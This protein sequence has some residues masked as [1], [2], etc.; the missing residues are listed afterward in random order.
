MKWY[1]KVLL[2]IFIILLSPLILFILICWGIASPFIHL[3]NKS[4]Y[5]KSFYYKEFKLPYSSH[6]FNSKQYIFYN[7][8]IEEGLQIKY[9]KQQS[10]DYFIYEN[11]IFIFPDFNEIKYNAENE[12]WEI[13]Y[14]KYSRE[15]SCSMEEYINKKVALFDGKNNLPIRLLVSRNYFGDENI[16][17]LKL[18]EFLYVVKNYSSSLIRDNIE[19]INMIPTDTK[20]LY[21]LMLKNKKLGGQFELLDNEIIVWKFEDVK[22]EI[23]IDDRDGLFRVIN[24]KNLK[25][26]ITHWHPDNYDI[27]DDIC[28]IGEIGNILVIKTF[29]GGAYIAYMGPKEK[30]SIER[31]KFR[32]C[33]LYFFESK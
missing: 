28:K 8:A 31:N 17:V 16:N 9:I 18:P 22:Y 12:T 26:E 29:L 25:L 19:A 14:G 6:I 30:C 33:K 13:I 5:L 4:H 7:Y 1:E 3:V 27:Y 32:I 21:E 24:N 11:K 20:D 2:T 10:F 15:T 23:S